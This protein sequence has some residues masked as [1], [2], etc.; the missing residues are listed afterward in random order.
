MSIINK[1]T[2]ITIYSALLFSLIPVNSFRQGNEFH[3]VHVY[4]I[5]A[6]CDVYCE[7]ILKYHLINE[8]FNTYLIISVDTST[9]NTFF[10][11]KNST[12]WLILLFH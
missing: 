12:S 10:R 11:A 7:C 8:Q 5:I 4:V 3:W 1:L 2:I 9:V 6:E